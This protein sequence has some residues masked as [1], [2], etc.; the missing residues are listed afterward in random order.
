MK[1]KADKILEKNLDFREL[2]NYYI[3]EVVNRDV[4]KDKSE[5][6]YKGIEAMVDVINE[7][8]TLATLSHLATETSD[9]AAKNAVNKKYKKEG[10]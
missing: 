1:T 10:K 8:Y 3:K 7:A 6:F 5:D 9:K 4:P 2:L